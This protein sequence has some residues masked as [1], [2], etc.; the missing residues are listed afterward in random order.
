MCPRRQLSSSS[1]R[2]FA[3]L[4]LLLAAV[5]SVAQLGYQPSRENLKS[6][7]WFQQARF[8]MFIH[9]GIYSELGEGEWVMQNQHI[10]GW[11]YEQLAAQFYPVKYDPAQWVALLNVGRMPS[12]EIQ[13]AFAARLREIGEWMKTYGDSIY[14]SQ[15]GPVKPGGWGVTT[16]RGN[17]VYVH[18]LDPT[19]SVLALPGIAQPIRS[20]HLMNGGAKVNYS[21]FEGGLMLQV[22][23]RAAD[24][25]DQV[26]VLELGS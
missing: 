19:L 17:T 5:S 13:P 11:Q 4:A 23:L 26:I 21:L 20:A 6:R 2:R 18:V 8:G 7:E 24:E 1:I 16:Q 22:P 25:I 10:P 9:W 12:G 15:G 14:G 3:R